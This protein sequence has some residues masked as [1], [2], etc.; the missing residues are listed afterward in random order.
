M[1]EKKPFVWTILAVL[2]IVVAGYLAFGS[3]HSTPSWGQVF[4]FWFLIPTLALPVLIVINPREKRL[5]VILTA[6]AAFAFGPLIFGAL[7]ILLP[8]L[9]VLVIWRVYIADEKSPAPVWDLKWL[10]R[11]IDKWNAFTKR[12]H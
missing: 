8:L 1:E 9:V 4:L 7:L 11:V 2:N 12:Q 6:Y 5:P 3:D 10:D